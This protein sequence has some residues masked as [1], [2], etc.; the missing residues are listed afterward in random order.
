MRNIEDILQFR[1]DISPFLAHLTKRVNQIPASD[2]L[3]RIIEDR[4]VRPGSSLVS[5]IRF[6]GNQIVNAE[7]R[8]RF[9]GAT[10]F[11][12]TPLSEVHCLL[13]I[14]S[15]TVNLEGYGLVFL[16]HRLIAKE[17]SPVFYLNNDSGDKDSAAQH[18]YELA[19]NHPATAEKILP[20]YAV[21]GRKIQNPNAAVRPLGSVDFRWEREWRQPYY[22]G[23]VDFTSQDVFV[24]LCPDEEIDEFEHQFREVPFIDPLRPMKW[25]AT[26]LI[27]ARQ[28]LDL[29][30]SV[31]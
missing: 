6:G 23:G 11:T 25:Y 12:E 24:G 22:C 5:D 1:G 8:K 16:K 7:D 15:R 17:V 13:D 9:F 31:V 26:K 27:Q 14:Q 21:F 20:L 29:R 4:A 19:L 10:C 18:L 3:S 28:R 2:I 30:T